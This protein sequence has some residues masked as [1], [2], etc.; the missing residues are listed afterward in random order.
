MVATTITLYGLT[1]Y[2]T[3]TPTCFAR[4]RPWL[5]LFYPLP[6]LKR[7]IFT[8]LLEVVNSQGSTL[9][10]FSKT[11]ASYWYHAPA[12]TPPTLPVTPINSGPVT[13]AMPSGVGVPLALAIG[14]VQDAG[15]VVFIYLVSYAEASP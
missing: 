2:L 11:L 10:K 3:C 15:F 13:N 6:L 9:D 4:L 14:L 5:P 12:P 8:F 7:V 1:Y